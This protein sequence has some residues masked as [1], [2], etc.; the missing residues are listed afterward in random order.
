MNQMRILV[1]QAYSLWKREE[2]WWKSPIPQVS[3]VLYAYANCQINYNYSGHA[4]NKS[5]TAVNFTLEEEFR[6]I[7]YLV[8][9]QKYQNGRYE[10]TGLHFKNFLKTFPLHLGLTSSS[11]RSLTTMTWRWGSSP[12]PWT[13][14]RSPSTRPWSSGCSRWVWSSQRGTQNTYL[15]W[16]LLSKSFECLKIY[17]PSKL[18]I[19]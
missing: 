8:R 3:I 17:Q 11:S 5:F 6:I 19:W 2:E 9:I 10:L 15:R 16:M 7:D 14:P 18:Y 4:F 12:T 13:A 1:N